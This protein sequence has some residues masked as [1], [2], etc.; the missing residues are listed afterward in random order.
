[1]YREVVNRNKQATAKNPFQIFKN[2][3]LATCK[4]NRATFA[5]FTLPPIV[6]K[7]KHRPY[8]LW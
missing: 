2:E 7:L 3:V 4:V 8:R 6:T 1:M 5:N